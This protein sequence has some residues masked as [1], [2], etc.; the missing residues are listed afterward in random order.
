MVFSKNFPR[1]IEGSNYPKWEEIFLS[2]QEEREREQVARQENLFLVRQCIADA[3]NILK[4]E[5]MMDM[6]SHVLSV[7]MTLFKKRASHAVYYKEEK[8]KEKFLKYWGK[9]KKKGVV[10]PAEKKEKVK[11]QKKR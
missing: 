9:F 1:E 8:C 6:Q 10:E 4:D 2:A 3:R 7:A 11:K 5:K